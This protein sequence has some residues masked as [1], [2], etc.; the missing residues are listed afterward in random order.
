[1]QANFVMKKLI[2]KKHQ[3]ENLW[4]ATSFTNSCTNLICKSTWN[5]K[6]TDRKSKQ[7]ER[8]TFAETWYSSRRTASC[9]SIATVGRQ[10][11]CQRELRKHP[12]RE[13]WDMSSVIEYSPPR[14]LYKLQWKNIFCSSV[15]R[16]C[17]DRMQ[18]TC[19]SS[20]SLKNRVNFVL[21]FTMYFGAYCIIVFMLKR[22]S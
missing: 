2:A 5:S 11:P 12:F 19:C 20:I 16:H 22:C 10:T 15:A 9:K 1:M 21:I 13:V 17:T 18:S 7:K 3:R 8:Q 4:A 6:G 14:M